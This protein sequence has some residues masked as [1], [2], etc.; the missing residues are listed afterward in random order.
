MEVIMTALKKNLKFI[1]VLALMI[2]LNSGRA[3]A[4]INFDIQRVGS[5]IMNG[6]QQG[7]QIKNE[8]DSNIAMIKEAQSRGYAQAAQDLFG[9]VKNGD[10]DQFGENLKGLQDSAFDATHSAQAVEQRKAK[11]EEDRKAKMEEMLR[12]EEEARKAAESSSD[13]A[14]SEAKAK[15]PFWKKTFNWLKD[16][17]SA[18]ETGANAFNSAK[19]GDVAGA[20]RNAGGSVGT[21]VGG[22]N[23]QGIGMLGNMAGDGTNAVNNGLRN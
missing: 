14:H 19:S 3:E 11:E 10:F 6:L 13:A 5:A 4:F 1:A 17:R 15:E 23:G 18:A 9:K 22:E 8:I 16:R 7:L 12:Q 2:T 20:L 21:V